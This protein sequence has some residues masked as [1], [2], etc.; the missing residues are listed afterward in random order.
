MKLLKDLQGGERG[1]TFQSAG[2][3][4]RKHNVECVLLEVQEHNL[5]L[6]DLQSGGSTEDV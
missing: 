4:G 3:S 5:A 6:V 1:V 2:E